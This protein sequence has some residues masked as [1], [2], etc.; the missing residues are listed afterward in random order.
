MQSSPRQPG[1]MPAAVVFVL[2]VVA[3][4]A[5]GTVIGGWAVLDENHSKQEHG[6][7]LLMPMGLAWF[8]ALFG[9]A[10]AAL[11]VH[12]VVLARGRRP[13]IR[14]VLA[15]CLVFVALSTALGFLGS[16]AAGTPSVAVLLIAGIDVA[17]GWVVLGEK[18]RRWF[19]GGGT[20][21]AGRTLAG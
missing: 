18:G 11:Q 14:V 16:L 15:V 9:W 19:S 4:H 8:T 3:A 6:Q 17:A 1:R 5:L 10:L 21:W 7:E 20:H 2:V 13:W 12:C